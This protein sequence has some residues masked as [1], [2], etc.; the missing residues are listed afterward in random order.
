MKTKQT[1]LFP[2]NT[3]K[4]I[5]LTLISLIKSDGTGMKTR[6]DPIEVIEALLLI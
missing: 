5:Q 6:R 1:K 4:Q 3:L 2:L